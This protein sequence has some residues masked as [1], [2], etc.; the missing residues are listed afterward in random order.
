M[1]A[2]RQLGIACDGP[3]IAEIIE[4]H[5]AIRPNAPAF[6]GAGGA[7]L[8]YGALHQRSRASMKNCGARVS[9]QAI[10]LR[11]LCWTM[12]TWR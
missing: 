3:T 7:A 12:P 10:G 6:V 4:R 2:D 8:S 9:A 1:I 11:S 5:A